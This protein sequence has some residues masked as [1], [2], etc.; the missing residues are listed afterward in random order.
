MKCK[1]CKESRICKLYK[2][3]G[4]MTLIEIGVNDA[5]HID[6]NNLIGQ[7]FIPTDSAYMHEGGWTSGEFRSTYIGGCK[8]SRYFASAKFQPCLDEYLKKK[9]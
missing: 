7:Q 4:C 3:F 6:R 1:E 9:G 2:V 8:E 5:Y